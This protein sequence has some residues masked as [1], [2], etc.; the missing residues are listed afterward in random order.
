MSPSDPTAVSIPLKYD[1]TTDTTGMK[2]VMLVHDGVQNYQVFVEN[3]N[4]STFPIVYSSYSSSTEL[5]DLLRSRFTSID[6]VAFVFHGGK[7]FI[8][9]RFLDTKLMFTPEDIATPAPAEY[10][11]NVRFIVN[12]FTTFQV[13]YSDFLACDSLL[14]E[15]WRSYYDILE[16]KTTTII[17]ASNNNTGSLRYGADW[18]MESTGE[19]VRD[20][21]FNP[22]IT[23]Y[24]ILLATSFYTNTDNVTY[25][26][27]PD[28]G[29]DA[30]VYEGTDLNG[31][32]ATGAIILLSS[33]D[34]GGTTY[35]VTSILS[36]AFYADNYGVSSISSLTIPSSITSIEES[37]FGS[38]IFLTSFSVSGGT[39]FSTI[40][41]VLF[42][43]SVSALICY[44]MA[45]AA[46]SYSI[47]SSVTELISSAFEGAN[48]ITTL[49][50]NS[51]LQIIGSGSLSNTSLAT[52]D[53]P[54][55]VTEIGV[56]AFLNNFNLVSINVDSSNTA[57]MSLAGVLYNKTQ[58][59]LL[60]YPSAKPDTTFSVPTGV[61]ALDSY[62]IQNNYILTSISLPSTLTSIG[63]NAIGNISNITSITIPF[64]VTTIDSSVLFGMTN[65]QNILFENPNNLTSV[66]SYFAAYSGDGINNVAITYQFTANEAAL[67]PVISGATNIYEQT[68]TSFTYDANCF[69]KG[70]KILC[71]NK[72]FKDEY[73]AIENL[74][75]GDMVKSYKHGYRA[76]AGIISGTIKNNPVSYLSSMYKMLKTEENG[77]LE[78][79]I[80]TGGHALLVDDLGEQTEKNCK[81]YNNCT[82]KIDDKFMLLSGACTDFNVLEDTDTYTY[83]HFYLENDGD[84]TQRFGVWANNLLV[85]TPNKEYFLR[86]L[87]TYKSPL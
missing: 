41:D 2:H 86:N 7:Q 44:P 63:N 78:D 27:D 46:T 84:D 6:R 10:S 49:T 37:A 80:I 13:K 74:T 32:G 21:Y 73:V 51:G 20:I 36:S 39:S 26:Y 38:N 76:I 9:S 31:T 17:G 34:V 85:E 45:N 66:G 35:N 25:R 60:F 83:Y 65:L 1:K 24:Q 69:N 22:S 42:N 62:A 58:T 14:F 23:E 53:I 3:A 30:S 54:A 87:T 81:M 16:S 28:I 57:Y 19:E 33:F 4:A 75:K 71:L 8:Q 11:Q 29:T 82:F 61:T 47:P 67:N 56:G 18:I 40:S 79:L 55:S 77:L 48:N 50:L 15:E 5:L 72:N 64:N 43:F 68:T 52:L 70:T 12:V 59:T